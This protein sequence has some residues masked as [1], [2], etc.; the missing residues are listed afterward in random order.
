MCAVKIAVR[1][2][3]GSTRTFLRRSTLN[4][5]SANQ[6]KNNFIYMLTSLSLAVNSCVYFNLPEL[7]RTAPQLPGAEKMQNAAPSKNRHLNEKYCT[8]IEQYSAKKKQYRNSEIPNK[9]RRYP[10]S[11]RSINLSKPCPYCDYS[12]GLIIIRFKEDK[13]FCRCGRCDAALFSIAEAKK[14]QGL[15][16]I[17][18]VLDSYL[19]KPAAF[20]EEVAR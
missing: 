2:T 12:T 13:G 19:P 20:G 16:H 1:K 6:E 9:A 3:T 14:A 17:G 10:H 7:F 8:P 11:D 5:L 15:T 4:L 18:T